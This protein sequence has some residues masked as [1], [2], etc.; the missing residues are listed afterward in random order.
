MNEMTK[1][2][3]DHLRSWLDRQKNAAKLVPEIQ[4]AF[5]EAEWQ[6]QAMTFLDLAAPE[7]ARKVPEAELGLSYRQLCNSL[8][9]PPGYGPLV[10]SAVATG[11]TSTTSSVHGAVYTTLDLPVF[12]ERARECLEEYQLLHQRQDRQGSIRTMLDLSFP[13]M[14]DQ[15]D[16]AVKFHMAAKSQSDQVAP[17]ANEVRNLLDRFKGELFERARDGS[18]ENMTWEKMIER[19]TPK[20][21]PIT[22]HQILVNQES[23]RNGLRDR[24]SALLKRRSTLGSHELDSLWMQALDHLYIVCTGIQD[25]S[26]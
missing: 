20:S 22:E 9:L 11:V 8:P 25:V 14:V 1:K 21:K 6:H 23:H 5:E 16:V 12:G 18:R 4:R 7:E 15:F 10:F 17:A 19:L 26:A 2:I 13:T 24:L 3:R